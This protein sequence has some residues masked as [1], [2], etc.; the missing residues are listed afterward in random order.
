[1][2]VRAA[3]PRVLRMVQCTEGRIDMRMDLVMRFDYGSVLPWVTRSGTL[4]TAIA[5]PDALILSASVDV[6]AKI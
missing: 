4:L 6:K 1:M 5:G 2:P 3:H